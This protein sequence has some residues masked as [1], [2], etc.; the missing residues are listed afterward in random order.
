MLAVEP[1]HQLAPSLDGDLR[2]VAMLVA[3]RIG[4][5]ARIDRVGQETLHRV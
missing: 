5:I 3:A 1:L 4:D 2:P